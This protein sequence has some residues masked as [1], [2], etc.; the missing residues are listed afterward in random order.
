MGLAII[1]AGVIVNLGL[2]WLSIR[3]GATEM[4]RQVSLPW[5]ALAVVLGILPTVFHALR[6]LSWSHFLRTPTGLRASVRAAFGTELGSAISPKAIGGVPVKIGLLIE[7]GQSAGTA[8]SLTML[9]NLEDMLFFT[10]V[11]PT[12][13]FVTARWQVPEVQQALGRVGQRIESMLPWIAA[14]G[15]VLVL[16]LLWRRR[17]AGTGDKTRGALATAFAGM[18]RDFLS[19]YALVGQRGK[20]RFVAGIGLASLQWVSR[21]TVGTAVM[22][23]IGVPVDPVLFGLLQWVVYA[24]MVFVPTP[25]AALGAEASFAAILGAFV[26]A[27]L[28]GLVTAAWRFLTFYLV[29]L[30]GLAVVPLTVSRSTPGNP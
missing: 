30:V 15:V 4:M 20:L 27:G 18:R 22:Y 12:I 11:A 7:S 25:G 14:S 5:L 28:L 26:P 8:T 3:G 29:L 24:T 1:L 10:V 21:C 23:G 19:A 2:A 17:R 9:N 16:W 6:V 13:A